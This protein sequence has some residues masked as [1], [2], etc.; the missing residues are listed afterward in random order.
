MTIAGSPITGRASDKIA[1]CVILSRNCATG[2]RR[3]H[4][5]H[6]AND[7]SR[8][9]LK[10][11]AMPR[12]SEAIQN[13]IYAKDKGRPHLM[14]N[15]FAETADLEVVVETGAISFPPLSR[16]RDAIT[17]VLVR[18]FG[19]SFENIYT[20][21]LA[22]PPRNDGTS[23]SCSWMVGFSDKKSGAVRLGCGHYDWLFQTSDPS[24]VERL[25]ITVKFMLVLSPDSLYPLMHW[26]SKLPYPWCPPAEALNE[27]P[28][29]A[30]IKSVFDFI[31][32][33]II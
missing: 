5:C 17:K 27:M 15:A 7:L 8:P 31:N 28:K 30:E 20:L 12:R 29:L 23:F 9:T 25:K 14:K 13:Y 26:L 32:H 10:R 24:L 33:V 3:I 11:A 2:H 1:S 21:C 16:G 4:G 22:R 18:D 19:Q 6:Q